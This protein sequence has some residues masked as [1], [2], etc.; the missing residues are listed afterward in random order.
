MKK[1]ASLFIVAGMLLFSCGNK[2]V[3]EEETIPEEDS[4]L[5]VEEEPVVEDTAAVEEAAAPVEETAATTKKASTTKKAT[6]KTES[7][8]INEE[9]SKTKSL[10]NASD[11]KQGAATISID[12]NASKRNEEASQSSQSL[13]PVNGGKTI[14]F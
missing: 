10:G 6:K 9:N 4:T 5:I 14:N 11:Y 7:L 3:Q 12:N 1:L 8:K 13:T 2:N